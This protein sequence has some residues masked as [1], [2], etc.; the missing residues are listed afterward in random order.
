MFMFPKSIELGGQTWLLVYDPRNPST[1][2]PDMRAPEVRNCFGKWVQVPG[3]GG[4]TDSCYMVVVDLLYPSVVSNNYVRPAQLVRGF[5]LSPA[6]IDPTKTPPTE[7]VMYMREVRA[8]EEDP[9]NFLNAIIGVGVTEQQKQVDTEWADKIL[10]RHP[11]AE[12]QTEE[13]K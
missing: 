2:M 1:V 12:S 8:E 11:F 5:K 13:S 10:G 3:E 7:M 4:K 6:Q 9:Q